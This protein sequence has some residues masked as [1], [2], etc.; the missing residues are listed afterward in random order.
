MI[1]TLE[2]LGRA[3]REDLAARIRRGETSER[4]LARLSGYTQPHIHNILKG[5]RR[6][7]LELAD[8]LMQA[9]GLTLAGLLEP[10]AVLQAPVACGAI[11]PSRLF[12]DL[13]RIAGLHP[14]P[15]AY[16]GR[17]RQPVAARVADDEDAMHPLIRPGD[18]LLLDRNEDLRRRPTFD[19]VWALALPHR[20]ALCRCQVVGQA[21]VLMADNPRTRCPLPEHLPLRRRSL[22][23]VVCGRV[24][25]LGRQWDLL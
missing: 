7:S 23:Q 1:I 25:W 2:D 10:A 15:S 17:L 16:A 14:F 24:A 4:R 13:Q 19:H 12:P 11:G 20:G 5:R 18:L 3:L 9:G 21:L 22:L 6:L 8:R